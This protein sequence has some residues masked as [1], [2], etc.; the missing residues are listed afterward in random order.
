MIGRI[1]AVAVQCP[2]KVFKLAVAVTVF[3]NQLCVGLVSGAKHRGV[4]VGWQN[5]L[6]QNADPDDRHETPTGRGAEDCMQPI[7]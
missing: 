1:V 4:G 7:Q 2:K 3:G 5:G 6:D